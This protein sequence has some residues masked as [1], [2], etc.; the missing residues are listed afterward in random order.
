MLGKD[1]LQELID[2]ME[3][4]PEEMRII[5]ESYL[6]GEV[7]KDYVAAEA[8]LKKVIDSGDNKDSVLAMLLLAKEILKVEEP[9]SEK[10]YQAMCEELQICQGEEKERVQEILYILEKY[11]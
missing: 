9:V 3:K 11:R 10:D 5:A 1:K 2:K 8:W 7:L 6:D 4:T